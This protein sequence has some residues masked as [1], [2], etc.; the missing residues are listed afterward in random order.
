MSDTQ[1]QI[2]ISVVVCTYNRAD[3]LKIA[4]E[5]LVKQTLDESEYEVLVVDNN[6]T[7]H[8]IDIIEEFSHYPYVRHVL[9]LNQGLSHARNRGLKEAKGTYIAYCDDDCKLPEA[10]LSNAKNIIE[11]VNPFL[12][13][14]PIY[15]FYT[16]EKPEWFDDKYAARVPYQSP[17][18]L[19]SQSMDYVQGG[20]MFFLKS[21]LE[22]VGGFD[23]ELGMRGDV[24]GYG[25][26]TALIRSI[27][28]ERSDVI[29]YYHPDLFVYHHERP[30]KLK[31]LR[32][33]KMA[34]AMGRDHY[35]MNHRGVDTRPMIKFWVGRVAQ[36]A[37]LEIG[38]IVASI[39]MFIRD[40][41][42]YPFIQNYIFEI[43][44]PLVEGFGNLYEQVKTRIQKH[45][46]Q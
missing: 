41:N 12:F 4:L 19:D 26:E 27:I 18:F 36:L 23:T 5:S 16:V 28:Q 24:I 37:K 31:M 29:A 7:D 20:N 39:R 25:E 44:L 42:T 6:S 30:E 10:W 33:V 32:R 40:R 3:L 22:D 8:T 11:T 34:F 35:R 13:G 46:P 1:K 2:L 15:P 21:L 9:E 14:G 43:M 17:L 38:M 45:R